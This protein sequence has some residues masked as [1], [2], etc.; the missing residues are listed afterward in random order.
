MVTVPEGRVLLGNYVRAFIDS[1]SGDLVYKPVEAGAGRY[2]WTVFVRR[3]DG[4]EMQVYIS[5][6]GEPK[7]LKS[8][9][10]LLSY[11]QSLYPN[12]AEVCVPILPRGDET[13]DPD[14][15]A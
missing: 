10:A 5:R 4:T 12:A 13:L 9:N 2:E 8:A 15:N 1:E 14:G 11:H 6:T 3:T 7:R